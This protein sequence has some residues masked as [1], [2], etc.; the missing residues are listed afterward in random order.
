MGLT[1]LEGLVMGTR[2]GDVAPGLLLPLVRQEGL[3][4]DQLDHLL[5][6]ESGL[7]GL[8][9]KADMRDVVQAVEAGDE[10]ARLALDM[11]AYRIRKYIGAYAAVL[12]GLDALAFTSGIGEHSALVRS[13]VCQGLE[14]LGVRLDAARNE[15]P[16]KGEASIGAAGAVV[17]VWVIPTD[18]ESQIARE[19]AGVLSG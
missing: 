2:S 14:W 13:K 1:P 9:G 6:H 10:R 12:E 11:F 4:A 19:T 8:A 16:G 3:T 17:Q 5:N 18:E 7:L 15:R